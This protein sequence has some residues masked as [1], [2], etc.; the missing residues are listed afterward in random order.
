MNKTNRYGKTMENLRNSVDVNFAG[1][2]KD[3]QKISI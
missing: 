1:N 3:Y 2:S